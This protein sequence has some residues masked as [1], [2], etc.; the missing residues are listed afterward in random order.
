M[1]SGTTGDLAHFSRVEIAELIAVELAILGEC[2]MVDI[3][4]QTHSDGI[5]RHQIFDVAVLVEADLRV[6]GTGR[7]RTENDRCTSSLT[8][9]QFGNRVD[10]IGRE[11]DDRRA[12]GQAGDLLRSRV[13]ELRQ[14]RALDHDD[15]GQQL[16]ENRPH[17]AGTQKQRFFLAAQI[18]NA[19]GEDMAAFQVA[20]ELDFVDGDKGGIGFAWHRLHG[21]DGIFGTRWGNLLFAG[22]QRNIVGADLFH[23]PRIDLACQKAQRQ[24]DDATSMRHHS[25][26]GIM[27]L[28]G[29][30]RSKN[31]R[32]TAAAQDHGAKIQRTIREND[33][34][35]TL[36]TRREGARISV[37]P[38]MA[39]SKAKRKD[40]SGYHRRRPGIDR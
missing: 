26:D 9:H 10:L 18:Q 19:V 39:I 3:E 11:G 33:D 16:F 17:R 20:R 23:Q 32:Y 31:G 22:D 37:F 21:A 7:Q 12:L 4:V 30:C 29:I 38:H 36:R 34:A 1:A 40:E 14:A 25:L 35:A 2:H 15:A 13:E 6:A 24:A 28:A 8:A 27:G 5:G